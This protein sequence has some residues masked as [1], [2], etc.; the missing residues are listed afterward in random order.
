MMVCAVQCAVLRYKNAAGF[1]RINHIG[2]DYRGKGIVGIGVRDRGSPK[3]PRES[4]PRWIGSVTTER[5]LNEIGGG[6]A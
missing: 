2:R 5:G 4:F 3:P 6:D 1:N